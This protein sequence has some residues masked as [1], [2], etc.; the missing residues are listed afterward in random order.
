MRAR[1]EQ[2]NT[3]QTQFERELLI[4]QIEAVEKKANLLEREVIILFVLL[5]I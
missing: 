4:H 2:Y 3:P 1:E 5:N